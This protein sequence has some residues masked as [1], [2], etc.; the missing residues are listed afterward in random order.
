M[1]NILLYGLCG[2]MGQEVLKES[3]TSFSDKCKIVCGVDKNTCNISDI[4]VYDNPYNITEKCDV[5]ID[6]SVPKA[7]L[8]ILDYAKEKKI[9]IV[10][11]TT[12]IYR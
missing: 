1:V 5:I 9:P 12:R 6:F 8:N 3:S 10:I 2:K 7:T 4:K 11:A